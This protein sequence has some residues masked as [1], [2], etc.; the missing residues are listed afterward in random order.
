MFI[1]NDTKDKSNNKNVAMLPNYHEYQPL[2]QNKKRANG[3]K[4]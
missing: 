2:D 4:I 3:N 1:R